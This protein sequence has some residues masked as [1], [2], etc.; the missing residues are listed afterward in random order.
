MPKIYIALAFRMAHLPGHHDSSGTL[1]TKG[2]S[3]GNHGDDDGDEDEQ[4][5]Y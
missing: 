5:W 4:E 3:D 2:K 1:Q